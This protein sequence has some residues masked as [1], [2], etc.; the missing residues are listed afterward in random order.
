MN[1]LETSISYIMHSIPLSVLEE[2][3]VSQV[4]KALSCYKVSG[5]PVMDRN[6]QVVGWISDI[7]ILRFKNFC[8]FQDVMQKEEITITEREEDEPVT[9]IMHTEIFG[10]HHSQNLKS[11]IKMFLELKIHQLLVF[12]EKNDFIGII[13]VYDVIKNIYSYM[14]SYNFPVLYSG[15]E[16]IITE[17]IICVRENVP[18]FE[19]EQI[20]DV[21][22]VHAI[23]VIDAFGVVQGI[24]HQED[25][26]QF[27]VFFAEG[28]VNATQLV[29]VSAI[30]NSSFVTIS[31]FSLLN[32]VI[33]NM[34]ENKSYCLLVAEHGRINGLI[35]AMDV[36]KKM[37]KTSVSS[38]E[39]IML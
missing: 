20:M 23:P 16:D 12:R 25:L 4:E 32:E 22:N 34:A 14:F 24:V 37:N 28:I 26:V 10:I 2:W 1:I 3:S 7:D 15:I 36:L 30:M 11:A 19:V 27:E 33:K 5:A 31:R 8:R 13:S 39:S 38:Y 21:S 18:V 6:S 9:N 29:P 17:N 35:S